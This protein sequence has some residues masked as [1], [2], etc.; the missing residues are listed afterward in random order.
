MEEKFKNQ[1][2]LGNIL[3]KCTEMH[4]RK[5]KKMHGCISKYERE[6]LHKK[7]KVNNTVLGN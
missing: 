5:P 1:N 2:I 7:A 4:V 6:M 3:R